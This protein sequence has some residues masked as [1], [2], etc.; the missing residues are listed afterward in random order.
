VTR[1]DQD[2][3][4]EVVGLL[5]SGISVLLILPNAAVSQHLEVYI[6]SHSPAFLRSSVQNHG[7]SP[8]FSS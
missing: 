5:L 7:L 6:S 8:N 4:P 1:T 3:H 2:A